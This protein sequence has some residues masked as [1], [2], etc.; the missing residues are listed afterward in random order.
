MPKCAF[1]SISNTEGWFIDDDLVH[2]PLQKQG[3]EVQNIPWNHPTNWNEYDVVVIRS[4]WD[5]QDHLEEFIQV[6]E[7]IDNSKALLLNNIETVKWNINKN[8]LFDLESKGVELVPT[9]KLSNPKLE[10]I[11][12]AFEKFQTDQIIIKPIIGANADDTYRIAKNKS[13]NIQEIIS[14]FLDRECLIQPFMHNIVDEGEFSLIY[15]NDKLSHTILKTVGQGDYRVQEEH[16]GGVTPIDKTEKLLVA[17]ADK[18]IKTLSD[19]PLYARVDLVRTSVNSFAL[20]ELELIEPC[21]Y[22]RF[23]EVAPVKFADCIDSLWV[24]RLEVS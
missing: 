11:K 2:E 3:W 23:D 10:S 9:I 1:L 24:N 4:P 14:V 6:L 17:T 19:I 18:I 12:H 13:S 15:F 22:F 8:Y 5:Y 21:L 7:E 20:M 16:G